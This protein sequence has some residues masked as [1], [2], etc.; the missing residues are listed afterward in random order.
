MSLCVEGGGGV[1]GK[2]R[3]TIKNL[4]F[5]HDEGKNMIVW[6]VMKNFWVAL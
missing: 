5:L 3:E 6:G 2:N 4:M 1:E